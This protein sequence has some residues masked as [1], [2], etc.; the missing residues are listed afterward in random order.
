MRAAA[1]VGR[2]PSQS[3]E[4][5]WGPIT[6]TPCSAFLVV[7]VKSLGSEVTPRCQSWLWPF[8]AV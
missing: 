4:P 3:G 2:A 7:V 1:L 5:F 6:Q 8:L